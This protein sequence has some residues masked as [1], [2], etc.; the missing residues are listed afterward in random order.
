MP[1]TVV[2][3][4]Y[5][6]PGR[7]KVIVEGQLC[8]YVASGLPRRCCT[9]VVLCGDAQQ[10]VHARVCVSRCLAGHR[11]NIHT[12]N[13]N[14]F[15]YPG[16]K[17]A[18]DLSLVQPDH[19]YLYFHSKGM[20]FHDQAGRLPQEMVLF[21]SVVTDWHKVLSIF[22]ELKTVNK[23]GYA[24]SYAGFMWGT[25]F[26]VRGSYLSRCQPPAVTED[27]YF[28]ESYIGH[29][30]PCMSFIDCYSLQSDNEKE[31]YTP[32]EVTECWDTEASTR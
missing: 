22:E 24:A 2:Y 8:E 11:H 28:F 29:C 31:W 21:R 6:L 10:L 1:V 16:I 12:S 4:A 13:E 7:W 17:L 23:V 14:L 20:V 25:F 3:Y 5:L 19:L 18:H 26:W 27:R 32:G 15:E 30:G 9:H